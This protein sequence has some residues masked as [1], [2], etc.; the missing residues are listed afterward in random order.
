MVRSL[1][2]QSSPQVYSQ[3]TACSPRI[4]RDLIKFFGIF[5]IFGYG[6][7][8]DEPDLR[9]STDAYCRNPTRE[10]MAD[11]ANVGLGSSVG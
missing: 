6:L 11:I 1:P 3:C 4:N 10:A 7:A 9:H 5:K 2:V 8:L